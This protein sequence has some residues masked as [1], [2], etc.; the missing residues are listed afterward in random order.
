MTQAA[1]V[2]YAQPY[3]ANTESVGYVDVDQ[4][5]Y[6]RFCNPA[7]TRFFKTRPHVI[8]PGGALCFECEAREAF[9]MALTSAC[10]LDTPSATILRPT[11]V[12]KHDYYQINILPFH[13]NRARVVIF[14]KEQETQPRST[15]IPELSAR[16]LAVLRLTA[17]GHKRDRIGYHLNIS[18]PTVDM[19]CRNLRLKLSAQT[20]PEAVAIAYKENILRV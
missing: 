15:S 6:I 2:L 3:D 19:H 13:P 11:D 18:L 9:H 20:M 7:A 12:T 8:G 16:E 14:W 17:K 5:G 10:D 4:L 1:P